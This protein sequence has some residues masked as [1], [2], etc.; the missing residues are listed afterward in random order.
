[1]NHFLSLTPSHHYIRPLYSGPTLY[2][3][4]SEMANTWHAYG[5]GHARPNP[6]VLRRRRRCVGCSTQLG[7][8]RELVLRPVVPLARLSPFLGFAQ[9]R[10]SEG[11]QWCLVAGVLGLA[12]APQEVPS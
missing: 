4:S 6:Q 7:E 11:D 2:A 5:T 3:W 10:P 12:L 1:M 9:C 8:G